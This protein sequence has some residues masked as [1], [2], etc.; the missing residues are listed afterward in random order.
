MR[1]RA[2]IINCDDFGWTDGQN[3]AVERAYLQ[4]VLNSASL[5]CTGDAFDEAV[6]IS[7][8]LPGLRLGVHLALNETRPL[9]NPGELPGL[10]RPDGAFHDGAGALVRLWTS[11]RLDGQAVMAEWRAQIERALEAG[12][13]LSR[14]D[15][16]KHVHMLPP[17]ADVVIGLA[18]EY[19]VPYVRL[20]FEP[21]SVGTLRRGPGG[22]VL[23][24]MAWRARTR[25]KQVGL[26][27]ADHFVGFGLSGALTAERLKAIIR[28]AWQGV[29]E[30]MVHPAVMT[31]AVEAL[32]RRFGWAA[33]YQF[34]EELAALCDPDVKSLLEQVQAAR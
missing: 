11:G 29:T 3:M 7:R 14:L 20:P 33:R 4:G 26:S 30:I 15:G 31:P 25:L 23:W 27:F 19:G 32:A 10:T 16:H 2:F 18:Q 6:A 8:R 12:V 17:L 5:L 24:A 9:L 21:L 22:L 28:E 13:A 34:E 1:R